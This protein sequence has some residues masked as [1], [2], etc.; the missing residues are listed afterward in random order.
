MRTTLNIEPDI[1]KQV[2]ERAVKTRRPFTKV[3]NDLLRQSLAAEAS[4]RRQPPF[5]VKSK[6]L[7]LKTGID[8]SRLQQVADDLEAE[9]FLDQNSRVPKQ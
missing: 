6:S 2:R 9:A 5:T 4:T 8:P 7:G 3:V 1:E